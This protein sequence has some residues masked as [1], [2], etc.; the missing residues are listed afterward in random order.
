[1]GIAMCLASDGTQS[2]PAGL[3]VAGTF[4]PPIID[5]Q[6]FGMTHLKEQFPI[7]RAGQRIAHDGFGPVTI[8]CRAG[9]E[10]LVGLCKVVHAVSALSLPGACLARHVLVCSGPVTG[11]GIGLA[12]AR[13]A[14][15]QP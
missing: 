5:H 11:P 2:K 6:H 15:C 9:K 1:M 13:I 14:A 4:Q 12:R 3:V 7:I 8:K 10:N